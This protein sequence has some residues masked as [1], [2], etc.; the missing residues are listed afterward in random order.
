MMRKAQTEPHISA[1]IQSKEEYINW[2][3]MIIQN[4]GLG[5]AYNVKFEINPDFEDGN[6]KLSEVGFIKNGLPYFAPNQKFEFF[7]TNLAENYQ[8]KIKTAFQVKITYENTIHEL[9]SNTYL[10]DLSQQSSLPKLGVPPIYQ[11]S[12]NL[13]SI[14]TTLNEISEKLK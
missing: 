1:I 11:I 14:D 10:I 6:I 12:E 4:I 7:L 3:D 9:R 13:K 5:P 8:D 2:I